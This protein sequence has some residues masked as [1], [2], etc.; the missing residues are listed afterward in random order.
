M[1]VW[2]NVNV[3]VYVHH[4]AIEVLADKRLVVRTLRAVDWLID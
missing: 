1:R 2:D 4:G 3:D